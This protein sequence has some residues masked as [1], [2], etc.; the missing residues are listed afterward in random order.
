M[1]KIMNLTTD[2]LLTGI[3]YIIVWAV[4][5]AIVNKALMLW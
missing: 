5:M 2:A 3:Y 4:C 1:H